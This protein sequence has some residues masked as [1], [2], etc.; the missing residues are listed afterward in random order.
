MDKNERGSKFQTLDPDEH[1]ILLQKKLTSVSVQVRFS[2]RKDPQNLKLFWMISLWKL[3][4]A[5]VK[6]AVPYS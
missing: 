3:G 4:M 2:H 6:W 5:R 1:V